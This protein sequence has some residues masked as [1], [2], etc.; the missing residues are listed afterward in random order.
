MLRIGLISEIDSSSCYARVKFLDNDIVSDWLQIVV[1][2]AISNKFFHIFDINEQVACL[3]DENDEEGVILGAMFNEKTK[4]SGVS[5]DVVKVNFSDGSFIEYDRNSHEYNINIQ[6]KVN[7]ISS[8]ETKIEA[9]TVSLDAQ[10]VSVDA[11]S[12]SIQSLN[13][14]ITGMANLT[15]NLI[16]SG[17]V[18]A[19][20]I[21]APV[22]SGPGVSMENGNLEASGELK[23]AS[24]KAG[25]IDLANHK[26]GGVQTGSGQ[27]SSSIP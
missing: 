5:K 14:D 6:G 4:P 10:Q 21:S 1:M 7:M 19:A 18:A 11:N 26:H 27:T 8:G 9:Q 15:G 22:I 24:V 25:P 20:S 13:I 2:G 3:M 16:V 17:S 12:V 23:G